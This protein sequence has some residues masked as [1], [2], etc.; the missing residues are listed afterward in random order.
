MDYFNTYREGHQHLCLSVSPECLYTEL[1]QGL[2]FVEE[3]CIQDGLK[4]AFKIM[5]C[6]SVCSLYICIS[7]L[8][9]SW[10]HQRLI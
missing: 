1:T 5:K 3:V 8:I 2:G 6:L 9:P 7:N 4:K 10:I